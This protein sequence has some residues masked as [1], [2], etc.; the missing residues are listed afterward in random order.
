MNKRLKRGML[1]FSMLLLTSVSAKGTNTVQI[2]ASGTVGGNCSCGPVGYTHY[3]HAYKSYSGGKTKGDAYMEIRYANHRATQ[4]VKVGN[5]QGESASYRGNGS[6]STV[7][8]RVSD[9]VEV[10]ENH[11][12]SPY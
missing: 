12:Y 11:S 7:R 10:V 5:V 1:L 2:G 3:A 6:W 4:N 9:Q 8:T